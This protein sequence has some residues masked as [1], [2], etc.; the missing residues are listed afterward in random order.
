MRSIAHLGPAGTYAEMA[1]LT[2]ARHQTPPTEF[3]LLAFRSI[4]ITLQAVATGEADVAVVPVENSVEGSVSATLDT[5]WQLEPLQ[6]RQALILPIAHALISTA[7]QLDQVRVVQ[8]HPQALAQCQTW[9]QTYLPQAQLIAMNSTS[10][11]LQHI[12]DQPGMAAIASRRAAELYQLPILAFPINDSPGNCTRFWVVSPQPSP[13]GAMTSLALSL[14]HNEPGALVQPLQVLSE[15]HLNMSRI[16][17]RPTKRSL[18][19]YLFFIDLEANAQSPEVQAALER[20]EALT[21]HL[22]FLGSY[23]VVDLSR[24]AT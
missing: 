1:A 3:K 22:R 12:Q 9:L 17:S 8:S 5:L 15:R 4:P 11:A 13:G 20:I 2:Y 24:S 19:E 16:E 7:E 18:G 10:E 23:D 6:I 14:R 21:E